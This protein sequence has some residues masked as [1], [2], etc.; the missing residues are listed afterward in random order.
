[1]TNIR[2]LLA[3]LTS[4]LLASAAPAVAQPAPAITLRAGVA[5]VDI[6]P[7][8]S[9]PMYGYAN[10]QCGPSAGVHDPLFAK[11]LVLEG[12]DTRIAIVTLDL[13]SVVSERL[14]DEVA[15][16]LGIPVL[17]L[18]ASH[19]HS[20]PAF[21]PFGSTPIRDDSG[22]VY[23][24]ELERRIFQAVEQASKSL[25]PARLGVGSGSIQLGYNRL[26]QQRDGRSRVLFRNPERIPWGPVD[27]E[28]ALL[29][30]DDETG[31]TRALLVHYATHAVVLGQTNCRFSADYPG[32]MQSTV[33]AGI[34]GAQVMFVQG[35]AGDIN[36]LLMA[37]SGVEA[38]DFAIVKTMGTLLGNEVLKANAHVAPVDAAQIRTRSEVL[39]FT[40]RWDEDRQIPV[41]I[42]TVLIGKDIA[43][44]TVPGEPLVA[45]QR[46]WKERAD[47][48]HPFFYGYTYTGRGTWAGYIPDVR[49]AA[50]GGYGA[51]ASTTIAV[52]AGERIVDQH[53]INLYGLQGMWRTA[54]GEP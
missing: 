26:Q 53:L 51:D 8:V 10:R 38:D 46:G 11:A 54:P 1:M 3:L 23:R 19:T 25:F 39:E 17:L 40:H 7:T 43:I 9:M 28:V 37:R 5:R 35:G 41:G 24:A 42:T 33:E 30:V 4:C 52:G 13:G 22:S 29:R 47:V 50:R 2:S 18:S 12:G 45:L 32:V 21:L 14:G 16:K 48:K 31:K 15:S 6:T 44:A 34:P 49:S 36:P 20:A 27:P